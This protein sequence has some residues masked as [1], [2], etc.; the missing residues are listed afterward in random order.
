KIGPPPRCLGHGSPNL[1]NTH[2]ASKRSAW[3]RSPFAAARRLLCALAHDEWDPR[4][5]SWGRGI[6]TRALHLFP[7]EVR[8]QPLQARV[9]TRKAGWIRVL[10]KRGFQG[11]GEEGE[12]IVMRLG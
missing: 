2:S 1:L 7:R 3:R 8:E 12:E 11:A 4:G 10:G 5:A 9:A 6:A